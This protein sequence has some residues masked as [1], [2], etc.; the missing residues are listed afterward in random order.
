MF[1]KYLLLTACVTALGATSA[2]ASIL[3][4]EATLTPLNNSGVSGMAT[5]R[6]NTTDNTLQFTVNATGL[7]PEQMHAQHIHGSFS[8]T[9]CT[10]VAPG[11]SPLAGA[12]L[13][14]TVNVDSTLPTLAND[15]DG[16]GFLETLEGAP[17]YGPVLLNLAE[18]SGDPGNLVFPMANAA[19]EISFTE[20]YDL[21]STD[22]LFDP[23]NS[24]DHE[25]EDLFPLSLREYVVHGVFVNNSNAAVT[26]DMFEIQGPVN[27]YVPLL[28]AAA[29]EFVLVSEVPAPAILGLFGIGL[30][31][32][33]YT[34]RSR[35]NRKQ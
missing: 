28:P 20:I 25:T 15:I 26:D 34:Q 2:T 7:T 33:A 19:G 32:L 1:R 9:G 12:C 10:D 21:E 11:G 13:D 23:L 30:A 8:S 27:A 16:D 17:A 18:A 31:G 5:A 22:L 29:G 14:G 35:R 24:I 3:T 4:Y 6:Y